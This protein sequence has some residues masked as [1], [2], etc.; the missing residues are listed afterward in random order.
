MRQLAGQ[1]DVV[2]AIVV[3]VDSSADRGV[4]Q[5]SS[6]GWKPRVTIVIVADVVVAVDDDRKPDIDNDIDNDYES[7][8]RSPSQTKAQIELAPDID[9]DHDIDIY[10]GQC[11]SLGLIA[12]DDL[13]GKERA[14]STG[15]PNS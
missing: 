7:V 12:Q 14:I 8:R 10:R 1:V 9:N 15:A 4:G 6:R 5:R 11:R 3:A 2:V 13:W